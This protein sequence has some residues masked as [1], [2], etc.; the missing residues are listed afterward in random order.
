MKA[1]QKTR[2]FRAM[3]FKTYRQ[4]R[5]E[6][7]SVSGLSTETL[8][9]AATELQVYYENF[10]IDIDR[11]GLDLGDFFREFQEM[12]REWAPW[13][14]DCGGCLHAL[15]PHQYYLAWAW[16]ENEDATRFLDRGQRVI[17]CTR[18]ESLRFGISAATGAQKALAYAKLLMAKGEKIAA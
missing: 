6:I 3:Y 15:T 4:T 18:T 16:N 2:L 12:L 8:D 9:D 17:G 11:R 5:E 13:T 14:E 1:S 10:C 7:L